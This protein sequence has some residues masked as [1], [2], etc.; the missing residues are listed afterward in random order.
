[1]WT[2]TFTRRMIE[3]PT[4]LPIPEPKKA[5]H[6]HFRDFI[7]AV[8]CTE[9]LENPVSKRYVFR[10]LDLDN[11]GKIDQDELDQ[12]FPEMKKGL[13]LFYGQEDHTPDS[14]L[15]ADWKEM[16]F[17]ALTVQAK[18]FITTRD[19]AGASNIWIGLGIMFHPVNLQLTHSSENG[20]PGPTPLE[21]FLEEER[22][23]IDDDG[24]D[25]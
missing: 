10:L 23:R 5:D 15:K 11:D 19:L 17:D 13:Q 2:P 14:T 3:M 16:I 8:L 4:A 21:D 9:Q 20:S 6:L 25:E 24:S 1:M 12:F 18:T 7:W 22:A